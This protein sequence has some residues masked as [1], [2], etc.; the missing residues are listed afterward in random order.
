MADPVARNELS[1]L[2]SQWWDTRLEN[3]A[4]W[5]AGSGSG[6]GC[7]TDGTY[8]GDFTRPPNPL[9]GEAMDDDR[10]IVQLEP[11][12]QEALRAR[13][14]WNGTIEERAADLGVH[15]NTLTNRVEEAKGVLE[16]L[17]WTQRKRRGPVPAMVA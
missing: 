9:V 6:V 17:W 3:W 13:Y 2:R 4:L 15:R 10:L 16:G 14:V 8:G 1:R 11:R 5:K 12:L 7:A